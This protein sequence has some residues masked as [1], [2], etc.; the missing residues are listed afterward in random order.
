MLPPN[1][2]GALSQ[3]PCGRSPSQA[4]Y[5][6]SIVKSNTTYLRQLAKDLHLPFVSKTN[7]CGIEPELPPALFPTSR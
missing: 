3:S 2:V 6:S 4:G 5:A 7:L 1:G